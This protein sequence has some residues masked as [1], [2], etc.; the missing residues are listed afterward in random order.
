LTADGPDL[1]GRA[2]LVTGTDGPLGAGLARALRDAGASVAS[3]AGE[4]DAVD[5]VLQRAGDELGTDVE[6]V[7]HAALPDGA[8][9]PLRF[10]DV[11]DERWDRVWEHG[12]RTMLALLQGAF[13]AMRDRGRGR[14]VFVTPTVSMSGA[15]GLVPLTAFV[16]GQR[17]LAKSAARQWGGF[18][19][20][21]NCVAPAPELVV[22]G[23]AAG[24]VS[25]AAPAL[26]RPGDPHGDLGPVVTFL[27]SDAGHFVTGVTVCA[28]GGVW[29]AP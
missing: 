7:V 23:T 28:D 22:A 20:T 10:E 3:H 26:G 1:S 12:M 2:A 5:A 17:L 13:P 8:T 16:E 27:A 15:A 21:V 19:V 14:F 29:M 25:L 24:A 6:I 11:T 18:G 9:D 4:L